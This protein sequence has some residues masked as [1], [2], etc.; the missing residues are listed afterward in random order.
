MCWLTTS[1]HRY[2][3][4]VV[5]C[6]VVYLVLC[7]P[8]VRI[9]LTLPASSERCSGASSVG[10][11]YILPAQLRVVVD[12]RE[13]QVIR[14]RTVQYVTS[15]LLVFP[16]RCLDSDPHGT[17]LR[18]TALYSTSCDLSYCSCDQHG[19]SGGAFGYTVLADYTLWGALT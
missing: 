8:M 16:D 12:T 13:H 10:T 2:M 11:S 4:S 15:V 5:Q 6:S 14:Y 7:L 9:I 17:V 3:C 18:C 1:T 19:G